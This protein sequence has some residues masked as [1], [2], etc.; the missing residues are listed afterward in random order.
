MT[1]GSRNSEMAT[2]VMYTCHCQGRKS[3]QH[4]GRS[5]IIWTWFRKTAG[6]EKT[7]LSPQA[8]V[9]SSR[10]LF[11]AP[12]QVSEG[13]EC[14]DCCVLTSSREVQRILDGIISIDA[15]GNQD[16]SRG[17]RH[18]DLHVLDGFAGPVAGVKAD[19]CSPSDVSWNKDD[20]DQ[21]VCAAT[22]ASHVVDVRKTKERTNATLPTHPPEPSA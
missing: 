6:M 16:I 11:P 22:R 2:S 3:I 8:V 21:Q 9:I 4:W 15:Q 19:R 12:V 10:A 20:A 18:Q 1:A 5:L 7:I 17:V 14:D 13:A